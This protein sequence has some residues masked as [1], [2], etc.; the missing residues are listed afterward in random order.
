MSTTSSSKTKGKLTKK[1]LKQDKLVQLAYKVEHLYIRYQKWVVAVAAGIVIVVLAT[2]LLNRSSK[3]AL[4]EQSYQLTMA[5]VQMDGGKYDVAMDAL[6]RLVSSAGGAIAGEAKFLTAKIAYEQNNY[7]QAADLFSAYLNDFSV[8][9]ELDC[10]ATMGLAASY[11]AMG[12]TEDAAKTYEESAK[13]YPNSDCAPFSLWEAYKLYNNLKQKDKAEAM[14]LTIRDSYS[15][16][17][18]A[19]QAKR[20]LDQLPFQTP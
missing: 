16:S 14:L 15:Q 20:E 10:A 5:K 3:S 19:P 9:D 12:K 11:Q 1:E 18:I 8:D 4:R 6:N 2:I 7:S 13:K 17:T